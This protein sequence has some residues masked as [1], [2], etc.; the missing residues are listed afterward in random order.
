MLA[1]LVCK[2]FDKL[3]QGHGL[4]SHLGHILFVKK[5]HYTILDYVIELKIYPL[6]EHRYAWL[7]LKH[8]TQDTAQILPFNRNRGLQVLVNLY[9]FVNLLN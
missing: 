5:L 4:E 3:L 2:D 8:A 9:K 1:S 7:K 6:E